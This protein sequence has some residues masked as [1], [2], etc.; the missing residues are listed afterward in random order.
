MNSPI[1]YM[2]HLIFVIGI[3]IDTNDFL[4]YLENLM[5]T[6]LYYLNM[7][8]SG[9]VGTVTLCLN[10]IYVTKTEIQFIKDLSHR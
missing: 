2:F 10:F 1:E 8:L 9:F 7:C 4:G 3:T 6:L 5:S